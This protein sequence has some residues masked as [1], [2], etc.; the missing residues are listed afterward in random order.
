MP[1]RAINSAALAVS[2]SASAGVV[3]AASALASS[4]R[5]RSRSAFSLGIDLLLSKGSGGGQLAR[6]RAGWDQEVVTPD[7]T[8]DSACSPAGRSD[9][10]PF[11]AAS[12][13]ALRAA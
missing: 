5:T 13:A 12:R 9:G 10:W 7:R 4:F 6:P 2:A 11:A 1:Y 3:P 8:R